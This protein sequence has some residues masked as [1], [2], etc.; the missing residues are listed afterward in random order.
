MY[1]MYIIIILLIMI[2]VICKIMKVNY[3][4]EVQFCA[5]Y[6]LSSLSSTFGA[7]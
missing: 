2:N 5:V 1:I 4:V 7:R 3:I 6:M